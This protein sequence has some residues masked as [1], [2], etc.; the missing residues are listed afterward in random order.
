MSNPRKP[1]NVNVSL[2]AATVQKK[3]PNLL[4]RT[5]TI[6]GGPQGIGSSSSNLGAFQNPMS[7]GGGPMVIKKVSSVAFPLLGNQQDMTMDQAFDFENKL[8]D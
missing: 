6:M 7:P 8:R 4:N 1:S 3:P 5:K 2:N